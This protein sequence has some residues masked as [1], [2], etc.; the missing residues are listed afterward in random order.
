MSRPL[1]IERPGDLYHVTSRGDRRELIVED[2]HDR[3][4]WVSCWARPAGALTGA[5]T[6]GA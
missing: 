5:S 6:P 3:A 4:A 1:R 2:N